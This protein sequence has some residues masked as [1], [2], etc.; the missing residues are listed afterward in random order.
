MIFFIKKPI[1]PIFK[2]PLNPEAL[3]TSLV[4]LGKSGTGDEAPVLFYMDI[5]FSQ[6]LQL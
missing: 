2:G 4:C 6:N 1:M 3:S 5:H